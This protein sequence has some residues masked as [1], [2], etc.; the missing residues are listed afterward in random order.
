[1]SSI[2]A[3]RFF[4]RAIREVFDRLSGSYDAPGMMA[5]LIRWLGE[6]DGRFPAVL[7]RDGVYASTVAR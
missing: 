2:R 4:M 6:L 3:A 1:M 5:E 7:P